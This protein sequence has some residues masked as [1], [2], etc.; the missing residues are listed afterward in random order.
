M[1]IPKVSC[2]KRAFGLEY[3]LWD[4]LLTEFMNSDEEIIEL[5]DYK[6]SCKSCQNALTGAVKA[7]ARNRYPLIAYRE[8][9]KLYLTWE[10]KVTRRARQ[11]LT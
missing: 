4:S 10:H 6:P 5:V 9:G 11:W 3:I 7:I 8:D 1:E 2:P